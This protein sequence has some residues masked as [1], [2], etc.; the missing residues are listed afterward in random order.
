MPN[1]KFR[2]S[3]ILFL[4]LTHFGFGQDTTKIF[5]AKVFMQLVLDYHPI[6][7]Q[8]N[9]LTD[10]AKQEIRLA[11]GTLDPK[12]EAELFQK[13]FKSK[14]YYG[15]VDNGLKIPLWFGTDLKF[16][17]ENNSGEQVNP[18]DY[19]PP[20]GLLYG[21]VHVPIG[22]GM[23]IDER[24]AA[25]KQAQAMQGLLEA[26]KV[27]MINKLL[28]SAAKA[29]WEWYFQFQK[30]EKVKKS[31]ALAQTRQSAISERSRVGD[32]ASID[33]VETLITLQERAVALQDV[34]TDLQNARLLLSNYL[35]T[36]DLKPLEMDSTLIP[37]NNLGASIIDDNLI[38]KLIDNAPL[39]HPDILKLDF[40][41]KQLTIDQKLQKDKLK[42][43]LDF[44]YKYLTSP[45]NSLL[46][47]LNMSYIQDNYK[48]MLT[49]SQPLFLRKERAKYQLSKIKV[50]QTKMEV[51]NTNREV[52]NTINSTYNEIKFL[53][54]A[55]KMQTLLAG[56]QAKFDNGESSIFM[57][58]SRES[59][60]IDGEI[61]LAELKSKLEKM[62]TELYFN[63]G[64]LSSGF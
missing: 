52:A 55:L 32:L 38:K 47:D 1:Y 17:Y 8:S 14:T 59:K 63:A 42:P 45:K 27:K 23:I 49:I 19:T 57:L 12:F 39:V 40:K 33:S 51:I 6:A 7:K 29:Y 10:M 26:E 36:E 44:T 24:R 22:Q 34:T 35:W 46:N 20:G 5:K 56:E 4:V 15:Y 50:T 16:G 64:S 43:N 9:M 21:G 53:E 28:F 25:I 61:K 31:F 2:I 18:T 30:Y 54:N 3:L 41:L 48:V 62:K 11:K 13:V 60:L 58:N 37:E